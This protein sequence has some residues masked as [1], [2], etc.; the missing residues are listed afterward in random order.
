MLLWLD[1]EGVRNLVPQRIEIGETL[2]VVSGG[3]AQGKSSFLESAYLLATTRSFRSRE[4]R[5]AIAHGE[6]FLRILGEAGTPS[7][8]GP[9][10]AISLG[11][12]RGERVIS[13]GECDAKL[14][15]YL[16]LLPTLAL[17]GESAKTISG[18]PSERRRFV[19][20]ATAAAEPAHLVDLGHYRK[21]L[22]QRNQLLRAGAADALIE[23]WD[24]LVGHAGER[25]AER[26][27]A[28]IGAWQEDLA[29]WPDL[30]P[31]GSNAK[32]RYRR[33]GE[34]ID[35]DTLEDKLHRSRDRDRRDGMT[36]I[37]PHRDDFAV[38][39]EHRDLLRFG[40][41]GQV[42][43]ALV[44]LTLAQARD[45]RLKHG[46]SPPLLLLDDAD[47]DLDPGRLAG[48]LAAAAAEGQVL[49]ATSKP[50]SPVPAPA[51]RLTAWQGRIT[52]H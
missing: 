12:A 19:D 3:N 44:A 1:I 28:R 27:E 30:F 25:I 52:D 39:L 7:D 32:L 11:R 45:V 5:D 35:G 6:P 29:G 18:S 8:P 46:G 43:S 20:R 40:S 47:T 15:E 41:A 21:A 14:A 16:G 4:V 36:T 37:G 31:E 24:V 9:A 48:L 38:E 51:R 2:V 23:P 50:G 33:S 49:A 34:A 22:A 42:R 26:R 10:M 13:V 17:S